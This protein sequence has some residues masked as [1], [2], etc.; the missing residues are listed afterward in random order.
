M[1]GYQKEVF[2]KRFLKVMEFAAWSYLLL[3]LVFL[4]Y[5]QDILAVLSNEKYE[6]HTH[7]TPCYICAAELKLRSN[8]RQKSTGDNDVIKLVED[9]D[10]CEAIL[11][12]E[13]EDTLERMQ[14][15]MWQHT[16]ING[17]ALK[18]DTEKFLNEYATSLS[19]EHFRK[20]LDLLTLRWAKY[21]IQQDFNKWTALRHWLRLPTLR[22][23]LQVLEK[24]LKSEKK[25]SQRLQRLLSRV[26]KVQGLLETV[27][28]KLRDT[29][30]SFHREGRLKF[31][32][33]L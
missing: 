4:L 16:A 26:Q 14:P 1:S 15:E 31:I 8:N 19:L 2:D 12:K 30:A 10:K 20:N 3:L 7:G 18:Q 9:D 17:F 24:E 22:R 23:R 13:L 29:Y 11:V 27:K 28:K 25:Q 6:F 5:S 32:Y 33:V 21:R